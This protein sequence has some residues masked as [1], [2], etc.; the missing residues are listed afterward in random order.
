MLW[1]QDSHQSPEGCLEAACKKT[2]ASPQT[3]G[4]GNPPGCQGGAAC[5]G[6]SQ[7]WGLG[8]PRGSGHNPLVPVHGQGCGSPLGSPRPGVSPAGLD[9]SR[10]AGARNSWATARPARHPEDPFPGPEARWDG[11]DAEQSGAEER[12]AQPEARAAEARRGKVAGLC[13]PPRP[14]P[15]APG[16]EPFTQGL[17]A[18]LAWS[19][20]GQSGQGQQQPGGS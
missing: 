12:S 18:V 17:L 2:G 4:P 19:P 20:P 16:T 5:P 1:R 10:G 3:Q 13:C 11:R 7:N 9:S 14:S 6:P 15:G 8:Q